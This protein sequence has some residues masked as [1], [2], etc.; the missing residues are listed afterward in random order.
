MKGI[1]ERKV[2]SISEYYT[3]TERQMV[4]ELTNKI[5]EKNPL[6]LENSDFV[7]T[8]K[9]TSKNESVLKRQN[10]PKSSEAPELPTFGLKNEKIK[11][12]KFI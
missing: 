3:V 12:P 10:L 9:G 4:K 2:I 11:V 5:K 8:V 1:T 7:W 6:K